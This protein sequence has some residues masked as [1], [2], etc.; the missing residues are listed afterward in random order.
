MRA[1]RAA[2]NAR[3]RSRA[4][5]PR[6]RGACRVNIMRG[7]E[8]NA[9]RDLG[10]GATEMSGT[11]AESVRKVR[12]ESHRTAAAARVKGDVRSVHAAHGRRTRM[13]VM[14]EPVLRP[15][16]RIDDLCMGGRHIIQRT[17]EFCFSMDAVL[18]AH[19]PRMSGSERVLDLGTGTGV[20]PLLVADNAASITAVELNSVQAELALRNVRM[21]NLTEKILVREW[22]YRDPSALFACAE[23]DLVFSNPPYRPVMSGAVSAGDGRAAAR[24]EL[25]ATLADTVRAAAYAL[26][27]GGRLAMVHLPER[28]SEIILALHAEHLAVKRLRMVQPSADRP[29]NLVLLEAVKGA[30]LAGMRHEPALIVRDAAGKYTKEIRRIYG[31]QM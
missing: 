31:Q 5:G 10:R 29:P 30:S 9:V 18:L 12:Q 24:H 13:K 26:R 19:F 14:S 6:A 8:M 20:I 11:S 25:T 15:N 1:R 21:N 3:M 28:L 23:Y 16:E 4:I 22:D 7:N 27:H 2:A 17:D